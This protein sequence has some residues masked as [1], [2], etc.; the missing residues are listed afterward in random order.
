MRFL[1]L[2]TIMLLFVGC[3][4]NYRTIQ[5]Q[6]NPLEN[7]QL[8]ENVKL[9]AQAI[10]MN[11]LIL[12]VVDL[13]N[14][15]IVLLNYGA[16]GLAQVVRTGMKV[17]PDDYLYTGISTTTAPFVIQEVVQKAKE[18]ND[19]EDDKEKDKDSESNNKDQNR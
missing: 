7:P 11:V 8:P 4:N 9:L 15:E 18:K 13:E 2:I 17:E 14:N 16:N 19:E 10:N 6:P 12:T 1:L 5:Y 3:T